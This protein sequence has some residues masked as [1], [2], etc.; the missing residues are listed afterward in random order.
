MVRR[1]LADAFGEVDVIAWPAVPAPAPPLDNPTVELPS[2]LHAADWANS[3][4]GGIAN[5]TGVPG[6]SMPVGLSSDGLPLALQLLAP[7]GADELL[8][9][10]AEA[11]ERA[12]GREHV[13]ARPAIAAAA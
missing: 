5:L 3:R 6:I 4:A 13:E 7:W 9:D 10:A 12:N 2:G 11:L 1:S 8:L